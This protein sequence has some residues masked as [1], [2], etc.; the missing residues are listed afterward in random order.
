MSERDH[1]D[2]LRALIEAAHA[3]EP[4]PT[5]ASVWARAARASQ[6]ASPRRVLGWATALLAA[7]AVAVVVVSRPRP[8]A[9][10][11]YSGT[12]WEAPTDF[13]LE[14]PGM[15][16]LT[17]LPNLKAP[18]VDIETGTSKDDREL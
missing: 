7:A 6:P 12:D 14:T 10:I 13:L 5:F 11:A 17:D 16:V 15:S 4:A 3:A 18:Q 9:P 8:D 1:D 2:K